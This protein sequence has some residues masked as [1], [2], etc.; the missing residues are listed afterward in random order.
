MGHVWVDVEISNEARTESKKV[1]GLIDTGATLTTLPEPLAKELKIEVIKEDRI[2]TAAGLI[3]IKKGRVFI[4]IEN[5]EDLQTIWTSDIIDKVLIGSV[6][7]ETLGLKVNPVTGK[8][9][10]TPLILY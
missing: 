3:N 1:R 6:T 7:L 2:Q 10:E 8:V 4:K 9:E 5:K